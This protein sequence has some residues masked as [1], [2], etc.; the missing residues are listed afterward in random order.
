MLGG[1]IIDDQILPGGDAQPR[2]SSLAE[3][4][5]AQDRPA[6]ATGGPAYRILMAA[7]FI[8]SPDSSP[9]TCTLISSCLED[10]LSAFLAF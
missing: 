5:S 1:L 7:T 4:G 3:Y 10:A 8:E 6:E 2:H 9:V